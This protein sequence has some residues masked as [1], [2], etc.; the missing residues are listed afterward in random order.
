MAE[1]IDEIGFG[2]YR[3]IQDT[4]AFCY[5]TDAVLLADFAKCREKDSL[6]D[7]GTGNGIVPIIVYAKYHPQKL[8]GLELQPGAY[9][10]AVR[11]AELNGLAEAISFYN[12]DVKDASKLFEAESFS[13]V[14]SNPPY[15]EKGRGPVSSDAKLIARHE[16]TAGLEDFIAAAGYLLKK[17]GAFYMVHRP[18]RLAD[19]FV[20]LRKY[21]LEPKKLQMVAPHQGDAA[22]IALVQAVKGAGHELTVLP[23]LAVRK[24]DGSY[25]AAL[26]QIYKY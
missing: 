14:T 20:L 25:T 4:D 12:G 3:L 8:A 23:E 1:R 21:D 18:S 13:V 6:I 5:G 7:L 19:I 16:T 22:N 2:G 9:E 11:N 10:L 15:T 17:G 26:Q 24:K